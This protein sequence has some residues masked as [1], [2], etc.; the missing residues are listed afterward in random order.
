MMDSGFILD[1]TVYKGRPLDVSGRTE[2]EIAVYDFLD[3]CGIE[4]DRIDHSPADSAESAEERGKLLDIH[5]SKNIFL[6]NRQKTRYYLLVMP[7]EKRYVTRVFSHRIGESRLSF[8]P[9]EK[10]EEYLGTSPGSASVMGL[11][12]D[13]DRKVSL[14][15][16]EDILKNEFF[17][18]HPCINTSSLKIRMKDLTEVFLPSSGHTYLPVNL[19]E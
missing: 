19:D 17:G 11:I 7:W 9:P 13:R 3:G 16:D 2:R 5:I 15:I 4:Y 6:C 14:F 10:M 1:N 18:C 12:N 8:G